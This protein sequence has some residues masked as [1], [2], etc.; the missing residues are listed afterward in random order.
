MA[1]RHEGFTAEQKV[2]MVVRFLQSGKPVREFCRQHGIPENE[3][4]RWRKR[5]L[6]GARDAFRIGE[7]SADKYLQRI[8]CLEAKVER[9]E[10]ENVSLRLVIRYLKDSEG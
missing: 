6:R 9:L 2:E 3:F 4:V 7:I 10:L 8:S 1:V 5:F